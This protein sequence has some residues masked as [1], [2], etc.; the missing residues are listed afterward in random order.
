MK[1]KTGDKVKVLAGKDRGKEGKVVQVLFNQKKKLYYV[2]VE[3]VNLLKK[4]L[5]ANKQGT[6]GQVIELPAPMPVSRVMLIDPKS[7]KPTRVGF[8]VEGKEKK[9]IARVSG[10]MID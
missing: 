2:V 10:E 5:R 8:K 6:Q 3:G 7:G 9:R 1:I 4:H